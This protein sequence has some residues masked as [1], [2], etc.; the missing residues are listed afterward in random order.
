MMYA[1]HVYDVNKW[2]RFKIVHIVE[3]VQGLLMLE[4]PHKHGNILKI[5]EI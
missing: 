4:I 3:V 5:K 1:I 2:H